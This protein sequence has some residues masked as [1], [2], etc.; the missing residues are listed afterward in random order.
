MLRGLQSMDLP[1]APLFTI[2]EA[3]AADSLASS[4]ARRRLDSARR[5]YGLASAAAPSA[6]PPKAVNWAPGASLVSIHELRRSVAKPLSSGAEYNRSR[7]TNSPATPTKPSPKVST[8]PPAPP[9]EKKIDLHSLTERL[10]IKADAADA[11]VY[12]PTTLGERLGYLLHQRGTD[13]KALLLEWDRSGSGELRKLDL[14]LQLKKMGVTAETAHVDALYRKWADAAAKPGA[15]T[16]REVKHHLRLLH[17]DAATAAIKAAAARAVAAR[18]RERCTQAKIAAE[19]AETASSAERK[20]A[21]MK[22]SPSIV[23]PTRTRDL[24]DLLR[25]IGAEPFAHDAS[26][27]PS[28]LI[29]SIS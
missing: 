5:R 14:R 18:A 28:C 26:H 1:V 15:V 16:I 25:P 9:K 23:R 27:R 3:P 4:V 24:L 7:N 19:A 8:P 17:D 12:L 22:A 10:R 2:A 21:A 6:A 29:D 13:L 11:E 20:L